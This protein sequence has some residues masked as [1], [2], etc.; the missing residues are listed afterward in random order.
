MKELEL[1]NP[2][3]LPHYSIIGMPTDFYIWINEDGRGDASSW[4]KGTV[5]FN[6]YYKL[7]RA[8]KEEFISLVKINYLKNRKN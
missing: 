6:L 1:G 3:N 2:F 4:I 8:N 7:K 5:A